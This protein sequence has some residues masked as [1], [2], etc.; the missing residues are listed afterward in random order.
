MLLP[1]YSENVKF[2]LGIY[3]DIENNRWRIDFF[4]DRMVSVLNMGF[5]KRAARIC[6]FFN[7]LFYV[8]LKLIGSDAAEVIFDI[9]ND[10]ANIGDCLLCQKNFIASHSVCC[11]SIH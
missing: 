9:L 7:F 11:P 6:K 5:G 2:V 4:V 8:I 1:Q 3:K 10:F